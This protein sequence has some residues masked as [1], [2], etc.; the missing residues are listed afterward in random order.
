M[1]IVSTLLHE[2][3]HMI[4]YWAQGIP[5]GIS[6][7]ME[8]PLV[9]IT[10]RQYGI[11]SAGGPLVNLLLFTGSWALVRNCEKG[12]PRWSVLSAMIVSNS[13]Y[14]IF[15]TLLGYAKGDGGEIESAMNLVGLGFNTAAVLF[16]GVTVVVLVIWARRFS[17][18]VSALNVGCYVLFFVAYLASILSMKAID[19]IYFWHRFPT[20]IIGDGKVHN[21]H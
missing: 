17:I 6:L 13:Y 12:T 18:R 3:G 9:D 4:F 1:G 11:G 20:I 21:P 7:V 19:S 14:L 8:F 2:V 15:R 5:A 16:L 10:E